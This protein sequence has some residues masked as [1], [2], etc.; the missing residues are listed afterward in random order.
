MKSQNVNW[1]AAL[2]THSEEIVGPGA[3]VEGW[4]LLQ[5]ARAGGRE[6]RVGFILLCS[7][8]SSLFA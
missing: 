2:Y 3:A 6:A 5:A 8:V 7:F 4:E 1:Q